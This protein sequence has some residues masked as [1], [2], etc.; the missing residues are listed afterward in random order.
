MP[1]QSDHTAVGHFG[2]VLAP[3]PRLRARGPHDSACVGRRSQCRDAAVSRPSI[4]AGEVK[5]L[6]HRRD[7]RA[8]HTLR[9]HSTN[10]PGRRTPVRA[11]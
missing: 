3:R 9:R 2:R 11:E 4:A 7:D 10:S 5:A 1:I 8:A 6:L